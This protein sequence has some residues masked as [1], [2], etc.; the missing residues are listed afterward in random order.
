MLTWRAQIGVCGR[1][2][3]ESRTGIT[4]IRATLIDASP[5]LGEAV[6]VWVAYAAMAVAIDRTERRTG[7]Q[8]SICGRWQPRPATFA[9]TSHPWSLAAIPAA[10]LAVCRIPARVRWG[11]G[12]RSA[13]FGSIAGVMADSRRQDRRSLSLA[14]AGGVAVVSA[15]ATIT[16]EAIWRAGSG[17]FATAARG[18]RIRV[19][20]ALTLIG[21]SLPWVLADL[22]IY[23][24]DLPGLGR[25]FLSRETPISQ[26][27][28][29]VHL[30]HHH[31]MDGTL[32]AMTALALSRPLPSM[33]AGRIRDGLSLW[34]S[35]LLVYGLSRTVEDFWNEQVV[36]RGRA[37]RKPPIVVR[38]GRPEGRWTW[39]ALGGGAVFID[40]LWFRPGAGRR[41]WADDP[42]PRVCAGALTGMVDRAPTGPG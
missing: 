7:Q 38:E 19:A 25:I 10:A 27:E 30:G 40:R 17:G 36:K 4:T 34:L 23:S 8:T 21:S 9:F 35:M 3:D 31:G 33:P 37:R 42:E 20:L 29:A 15:A 5:C 11:A 18:D 6:A 12:V 26:G 16:V 14:E 32:L 41:G 1:R 39:M 22:G 13:M 28:I 24:A 2:R